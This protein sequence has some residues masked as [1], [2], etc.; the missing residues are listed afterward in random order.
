[1]TMNAKEHGPVRKD[2]GAEGGG[3]AA[4]KHTVTA[5]K[6]CMLGLVA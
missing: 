2:T 5:I 1:M 6:Q 3:H 4:G